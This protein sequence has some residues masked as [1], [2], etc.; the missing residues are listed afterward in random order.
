VEERERTD[1]FL[2][3]VSGLH[4]V[5]K[6][7]H[8]GRAETTPGLGAAVRV[9]VEAGDK[10]VRDLKSQLELVANLRNAIS[11][12][13]YLNGAAVAAPRESFVVAT[14]ELLERLS[15]R[16]KA[17]VSANVPTT[18][19][20]DVPLSIA[21]EA[22]AAAD[23]SQ[24]PIL[25]GDRYRGLLTTNAVARWVA[26]HMDDSGG[27]LITAATVSEV[28]SYVESFETVRFAAP[29]ASAAQV[30]SWMTCPQPPVAVL[31]TASGSDREP[32]QRML[33]AAD[34]P[35]LQAEVHVS[36]R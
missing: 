26:A 33:V 19:Q 16:P 1:R 5:L 18:F 36:M 21:L 17:I 29:S 2:T 32:I 10:Q 22:M 8:G 14:E 13:G 11:H 30:V 4:D 27:V 34:V 3:A 12:D 31:F 20:E 24:A 7:R 25:S 9:L 6:K 23:I 28:L 15:G 35:R